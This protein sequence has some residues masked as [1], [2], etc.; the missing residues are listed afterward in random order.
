MNLAVN[1]YYRNS[2]K[3]LGN[4]PEKIDYT[5]KLGNSKMKEIFGKIFLYKII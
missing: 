4:Y 1:K 2:N 3:P 5:A